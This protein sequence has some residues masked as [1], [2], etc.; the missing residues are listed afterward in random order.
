[1]KLATKTLVSLLVASATMSRQPTLGI[2]RL[3]EKRNQRLERLLSRHDR[4]CELR[5]SI[6]GIDPAEFRRLNKKQSLKS[7]AIEY[8]FLDLAS[9]R[10][11]LH[12]K[13]RDELH[14]RGW[15]ASRIE[16]RLDRG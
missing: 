10:K 15:S 4:K 14:R 2:E 3:E 1:M 6:F 13:I 5:A 8:G 11:A 7:L 9:Y 12:G 16:A